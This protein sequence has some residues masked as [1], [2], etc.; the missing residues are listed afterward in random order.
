[1]KKVRRPG[2]R[3]DFPLDSGKV[4]VEGELL[5]DAGGSDAERIRRIQC[6]RCKIWITLPQPRGKP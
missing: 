4:M 5:E 2:C 1:M 6:P 3:L